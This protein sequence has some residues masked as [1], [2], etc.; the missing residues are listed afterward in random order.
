MIRSR[1]QRRYL[2]FWVAALLLARLLPAVA[3][4]ANNGLVSACGA[5]S[6]LGFVVKQAQLLPPAL[7]AQL[8]QDEGRSE[9]QH[10]CLC[11]DPPAALTSSSFIEPVPYER[12]VVVPPQATANSARGVRQWPP[13]RGPPSV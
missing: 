10:C 1:A 13:S 11:V 2:R 8:L 9:A 3:G 7:Q 5:A 12:S 4:P 6:P